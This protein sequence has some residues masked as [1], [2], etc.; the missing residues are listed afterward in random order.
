MT[1][2][3]QN[4]RPSFNV[5]GV[6]ALRNKLFDDEIIQEYKHTWLERPDFEDFV[7]RLA[8]LLAIPAEGG[9]RDALRD[10]CEYLRGRELSAEAMHTLAW[11]LAGNARL[12]RK[13]HPVLPWAGIPEPA[14]MPVQII[15]VDFDVSRKGKPGGRFRFKFLAG[16]ACPEETE[17]FWSKS[18]CH[19]LAPRLGFPRR[20]RDGF[21][22]RD[23]SELFNLR[24]LVQVT[25]GV[26]ELDF[27][28][29]TVTSSL[30]NWNRNYLRMRERRLKGF[31]CPRGFASDV[32]KP[33][34]RC[35]FGQ[36]RCPA[37]VRPY[38]LTKLLCDQCSRAEF[39]DRR[40]PDVCI[41]CRQENLR[42]ERNG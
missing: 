36:D 30:K 27:E 3:R 6:L 19:V 37:A 40:Y 31:R 35:P 18:Y 26:A 4:R 9:P 38:T 41:K 21:P 12:L 39:H 10:S 13:S 1:S 5:P 42:K 8:D 33:C 7:E 11:R 34:Y 20:V 28:Q 16:E 2:R 29:V 15:D 22:F 32:S 24:L 14:W 17:K 25:P 23:V